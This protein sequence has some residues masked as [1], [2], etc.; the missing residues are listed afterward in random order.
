MDTFWTKIGIGKLVYSIKFRFD[1]NG[2]FKIDSDGL[3]LTMMF[4]DLKKSVI[5]EL[6]QKVRKIVLQIY[7]HQDRMEL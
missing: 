7:Q 5:E 4:E 3:T 6:S 1:E 2:L